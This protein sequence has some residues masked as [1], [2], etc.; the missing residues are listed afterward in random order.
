MM[1]HCHR[2]AAVAAAVTAHDGDGQYYQKQI[3]AF[4]LYLAARCCCSWYSR[5][6]PVDDTHWYY[7]DHYRHYRE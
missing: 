6:S 3:V 7:D 5:I 1:D 2:Y 4:F